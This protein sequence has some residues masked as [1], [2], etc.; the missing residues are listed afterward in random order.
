MR[1]LP[2]IAVVISGCASANSGGG[3]GNSDASDTPPIDALVNSIDAPI[4]IDAALSQTLQ[5]TQDNTVAAANSVACGANGETDENSWYRVFS[6]AEHGITTQFFV[7]QVT[8]SVQES[9]GSPPVQVKVGTYSGTLGATTLDVAQITPLASTTVTVPPTAAGL[10]VPAPLT[11]T[12][13]A[14]AQVVVEILSPNLSGTGNFVYIGASTSAETRPGYIRAPACA[15][16]T[17]Q[18]VAVTGF[19]NSHLIITLT[20]TH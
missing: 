10:S 20:G 14:N 1:W 3:N 19:P 6:L 16:A 7:N 15:I 8:F 17:P 2:L 5:Q 11:A 12:I 4:S 9:A 18:T 13:P